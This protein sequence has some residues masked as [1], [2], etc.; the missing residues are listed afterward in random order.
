V[1]VRIALIHATPL[2]M[3]PIQAA[4]RASWPD[5]ELMNILDDSLSADRMRAD[6]LP[7]EMNSR[8]ERLA[9]YAADYGANGVLFTCSAFGPAID[10]AARAV[11]IPVLKPNEAMYEAAFALGAR[12]G[13][14]AT[15]APAVSPMVEE[16]DA[17]AKLDPNR[18]TLVPVLAEGAMDAFRSGDDKRH[19]AL[20]AQAATRLE[21]VD[22]IMLAQF[23][24]ARAIAA[25]RSRVG[26]PV[27]T[28]PDSAVAKLRSRL[29]A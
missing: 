27:L 18:P 19:D 1:S 8:F 7:S 29:G 17:M 25:V 4:F 22:A 16:F 6:G 10:A 14:V 15:F 26:V 20:I 12:I 3:A 28:S 23:S 2:A 9:C 13:L 21:K 11:N 24:M 5:A